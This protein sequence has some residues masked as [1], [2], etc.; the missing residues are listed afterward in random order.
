[1]V[2]NLDFSLREDMDPAV[3]IAKAGLADHL[4]ALFQR[5]LIAAT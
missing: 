4:D 3:A 5:G 1:V 2:S